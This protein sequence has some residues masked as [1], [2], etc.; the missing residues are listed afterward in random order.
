[1]QTMPEEAAMPTELDDG[2]D[3][4]RRALRVL[5]MADDADTCYSL[6][7]LLGMWGFQGIAVR[8]GP[9]ALEAIQLHRPHIILLDVAMPAM[10]GLEVAKRV[11]EL[12]PTNG[13]R[14]F[15]ISMSGYADKHT[16]QQSRRAGIDLHFAKPTI[17]TELEPLLRRLQRIDMPSVERRLSESHHGPWLDSSLRYWSDL[18]TLRQ[19]LLRSRQVLGEAEAIRSRHRGVR[20]LEER[21]Q[22][23]AA[24]CDHAAHF[25]DENE[26]GRRLVRSFV[27]WGVQT[28]TDP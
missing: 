25:M 18:A 21:L 3:G 28:A 16:R 7:M 2:P 13:K 19:S 20:N 11:R 8:S 27:K 26:R 14:P 12:I 10:D 23:R 6:G 17:L 24:W 5:I 4:Q 15:I 9:K 22:L 1:M